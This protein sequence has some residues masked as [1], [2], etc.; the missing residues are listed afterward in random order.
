MLKRCLFWTSIPQYLLCLFASTRMLAQTACVPGLWQR[1]AQVCEYP[2]E[3]F[4]LAMAK[5]TDARHG[6]LL[7]T[8]SGE[9]GVL[10]L[11]A[12]AAS[13]NYL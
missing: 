7:L 8:R 2:A 1:R 6:F 11:P 12:Q 5:S 13:E 4:V 3:Q 9:I 10:D